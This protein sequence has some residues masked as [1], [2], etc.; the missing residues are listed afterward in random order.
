[1][2]KVKEQVVGKRT[3]H[4]TQLQACTSLAKTANPPVTST[5]IKAETKV[6]AQFK[7]AHNFTLDLGDFKSPFKL[8]FYSRFKGRGGSQ[9]PLKSLNFTLDL[10]EEGDLK[11]P[12]KLV[13]K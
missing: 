3:W 9:I 2:D 13:Y 6:N 7:A 10:R 12:F 5:Q 4:D 1:M 8:I 11:S